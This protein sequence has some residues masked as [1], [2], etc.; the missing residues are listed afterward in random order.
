MDVIAED[1]DRIIEAWKH[2]TYDFIV[3]GHRSV[4]TGV[5]DL[6]RRAPN[7]YAFLTGEIDRLKS[8]IDADGSRVISLMEHAHAEEGG[9]KNAAELKTEL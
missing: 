4:G 5:A 6:P 9:T 1:I 3:F 2:G 7:T 8:T